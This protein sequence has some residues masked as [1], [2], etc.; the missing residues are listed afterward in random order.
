MRPWTRPPL[1]GIISRVGGKL[2]GHWRRVRGRWR[3]VA[4][5]ALITVLVLG[6]GFVL[7]A[8][9]LSTAANVAQL[10]SLAHLLVGVVSWARV[11]KPKLAV[12]PLAESFTMACDVEPL[13]GSQL[14]DFGAQGSNVYPGGCKFQL[15]LGNQGDRPFIIQNMKITVQ[16]R[17]FEPVA[18][19]KGERLYGAALIPHQLFVELYQSTFSGWWMISDG[20]H[21]AD[22]PRKFDSTLQDIL[23]SPGLPRLTFSVDP[24][25]SELID[26]SFLVK[27]PG[28]YEV[29]VAAMA[30]NAAQ[31]HAAKKTSAISLCYSVEKLVSRD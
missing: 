17:E 13:A 7:R 3:W 29:R 2:R 14:L 1:Q 12:V 25:K 24:G 19:V 6:L 4:A 18:R 8:A 27:E 15:N 16:R 31:E 23:A 28:L 26:G 11:R 22:T 30:V 5:A 20:I 9:G 21:L 10:V